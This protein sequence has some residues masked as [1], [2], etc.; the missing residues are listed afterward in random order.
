[1][2]VPSAAMRLPLS[3]AVLLV[4]CGSE[5]PPATSDVPPA[6]I[7]PPMDRATPLCTPGR[8]KACPCASGTM[9]AQTCQPDGTYSACVCFDAGSPGD[10]TVQDAT[11][12]DAGTDAGLG[13]AAVA[14]DTADSS[15]PPARSVYAKCVAGEMCT[16]GAACLAATVAVAGMPQ[17]CQ[18]TALCP[19]GAAASCPGYVAGRVECIVIGGNLAGAQCY[20]LCN[21]TNDC[22]PF[23]TT[24][25]QI[26]MPAGPIRICVPTG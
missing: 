2:L 15:A 23:N 11:S 25:T 10:A 17:G 9:G 7:T 1:M 16:M 8:T 26:M 6:D 21:S 19:T 14:D 12:Q 3:F 13:D 24:C 20:R 5:P 22:T 18:C 4:A